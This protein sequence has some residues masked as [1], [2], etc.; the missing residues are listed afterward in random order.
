MINTDY[1]MVEL[2][3]EEEFGPFEGSMF[4]GGATAW[5]FF[6]KVSSL[7]KKRNI[8]IFKERKVYG[9]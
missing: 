4:I 7:K 6:S 8:G 3:P 9:Y 5:V 1:Q 2:L